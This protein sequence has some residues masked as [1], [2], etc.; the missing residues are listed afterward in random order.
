MMIYWTLFEF[1]IDSPLYLQFD[2]L[3]LDNCL[4]VVVRILNIPGIERKWRSMNVGVY[5]VSKI[6]TKENHPILIKWKHYNYDQNSFI[7]LLQ[8]ISVIDSIDLYTVNKKVYDNFFWIAIKMRSS[9][10]WQTLHER[11][12]LVLRNLLNFLSLASTSTLIVWIDFYCCTLSTYSTECLTK[13]CYSTELCTVHY[14]FSVDYF[15]WRL[16]SA[17]ENE[18]QQRNCRKYSI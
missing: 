4:D 8:S 6:K 2:D 3:Q 1:S 16:M 5:W 7:A 17:S 13:W 12:S 10:K 9:C 14:H 18:Q 15:C 11:Y